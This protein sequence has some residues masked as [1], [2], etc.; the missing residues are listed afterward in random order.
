MHIGSQENDTLRHRILKL[1]E[2]KEVLEADAKVK[3]RSEA[4]SV[5]RGLLSVHMVYVCSYSLSRRT[6]SASCR[7]P[8]IL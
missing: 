1:S 6:S 8:R 7:R 5:R 2:K 4:A 3:A